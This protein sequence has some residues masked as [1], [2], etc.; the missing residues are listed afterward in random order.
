MNELSL[1]I[2]STIL[3]LTKKK[4]NNDFTEIKEV[5][6][7]WHN[8]TFLVISQANCKIL[9]QKHKC[10]LFDFEDL[11][12]IPTSLLQFKFDNIFTGRTPC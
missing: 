8:L 7:F 3:E 12:I 1:D 10:T 6:L 4:F 2:A 9:S 11:Q 5:K